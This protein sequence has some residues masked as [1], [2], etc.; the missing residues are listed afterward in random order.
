M[1]SSDQVI[2]FVETYITIPEGR[3]VGHSMVLMEWQKRWLREVFD[4]PHGTRRAILSMARKN[5]KTSLVAALLLAYIVGPLAVRNAQVFSAALSREQ[6]ALT[7]QLMAKMVRMNAELAAHC[8]I[9]DSQREMLCTLTGVR[10][11]ALSADA[12]TAMG[13]S[14]VAFVFDEAG[15]VEGPHC[16][17]F[18]ALHSGQGAHAAPIEFV[19]STQAAS[20]GDFLS[21][22]LD[23]ARSGGDPH[24]VCHVYEAPADCDLL[25]E[26][27]WRAANP[28]LGVILDVAHLRSMAEEASRL[29]AREPAF[30]NLVLN[31]RVQAVAPFVSRSLWQKNSA[32]PAPFGPTTKVWAG[33]DLS[34]VNDLTALVCVHRVGDVWQVLPFM[35]TPAE[36]VVERGRRDH[37]AYAQWVKSGHLRTTPGASISHDTLAQELLDLAADCD[38]QLIGCD[39]WRLDQLK[40]AMTRAGAPQALIDKLAPFGQGFRDMAPALTTLEGELLNGR[41]AHGNHPALTMCASNAKVDADAAGNRKLDKVKSTGRIDGMVALAMAVGVAA[42]DVPA[43]APKYSI[44]WI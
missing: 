7:F 28:A 3:A 22:M 11:R 4:N 19:I 17:L 37:A 42:K 43:P 12:S 36:G 18:D 40:A 6:A 21:L 15:Q 31:Q 8:V 24:V 38:L 20:D 5:S 2:E 34:S 9:R 27:A 35:Y 25:D 41:L 32:E 44:Q 29:P 33:L 10:F 1:L 13:T 30:R 16:P 23:D 39:R 26:T 14:P